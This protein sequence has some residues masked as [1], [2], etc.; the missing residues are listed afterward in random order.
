MTPLIHTETRAGEP[1]QAGG[2]RI[3]PLAR[4]T[5]LGSLHLPLGLIWNRPVAV[6]VQEPD[7]RQQVLPVIDI[8]RRAQWILLG[9]GL[10]ASLLLWLSG[11]RARSGIHHLDNNPSA[12]R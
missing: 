6:G 2:Q 11:R 3:V 12:S 4:I 7:G 5:R 8:T 1:L 10:L 9:A